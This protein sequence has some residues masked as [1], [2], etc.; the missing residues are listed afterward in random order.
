MTRPLIRNLAALALLAAVATPVEARAQSCVE[1]DVNSELQ[2]LRRL[3]LDLRGKMPTIEE[4]QQVID[5]GAIPEGFID[6]ALDS[7]DFRHQY[8]RFLRDLLHINLGDNTVA[9]VVN[10]LTGVPNTTDVYWQRLRGPLYRGGN[11]PM[12]CLDQPA[13][14]T[15]GVPD[16]TCS[17]G[18][19]QEGW[20]LVTPYWNP[21]AQVKVCAFDAQDNAVGNYGPCNQNNYDA[22][23]GCGPNLDYCNRVDVEPGTI[24]NKTGWV[25][26]KTEWAYIAAINEQVTRIGT[27]ILEDDRPYTDLITAQTLQVNGPL[28]HLLVNKPKIPNYPEIDV[29]TFLGPIADLGYTDDDVWVDVEMNAPGTAGVLTSVFY[30]LKNASNRS[31]ANRF[32]QSFLCKDF[33]G[34]PDGLP[35]PTDPLALTPNLMVREGCDYCHQELEPAAA[36]WG[37]WNKI[38]VEHYPSAQFPNQRAECIGSLDP[39][40]D[41]YVTEATHPDEEPYLGYFEPLAFSSSS[42]GF[43]DDAIADAVDG[44]PLA[45]AQKAID[46]GS[47]AACTTKKVYGWVMGREAADIDELE[48][49]VLAA[50]FASGG[51]DFKALVRAL[52]TSDAYRGHTYVL[53]SAKEGQ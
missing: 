18:V 24:S 12:P 38:G 13:T 39:S 46:D 25:Y 22:E 10:T 20:V 16:V 49:S 29:S 45:L 34:P 51:Y 7:E 19:C 1:T 37:R 4:Y 33:V 17:N 8:G 15:D 42:R 50:E 23:C 48:L 14:F 40:C 43:G 3:S 41:L 6:A 27:R 52:V 28:V 2:Y 36:H 44:G 30:L 21:A 32:Y 35:P 5:T 26:H 11:E 9:N 53:P 31:R 47:F